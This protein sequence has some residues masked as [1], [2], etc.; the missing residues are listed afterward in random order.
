[1]KRNPLA[2]QKNSSFPILESFKRQS[3]FIFHIHCPDIRLMLYFFPSAL[4]DCALLLRRGGT[5]RCASAVK[6]ALIE[7]DITCFDFQ[8]KG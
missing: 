6:F 5:V 4:L 8:N 3:G 1:M 2:A 7:T